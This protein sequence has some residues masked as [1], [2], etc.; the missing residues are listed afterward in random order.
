MFLWGKELGSSV[1]NNHLV[2]ELILLLGD[3]VHQIQRERG[4]A[5]L[6]IDSMGRIFSRRFLEQTT[7][8]DQSIQNFQSFYM[9]TEVR[10]ALPVNFE[11]RLKILSKKYE[12]LPS[13]RDNIHLMSTRYTKALNDYTFQ[14]SLP[15]IDAMIELAQRAPDHNSALVSA[16]SNFVQWKEKVGLER[17]LGARGFY[18]FS[19]RNQEFCDR[20]VTLIA[21]QKSYQETFKALASPSQLTIAQNAINDDDLSALASINRLLE[22]GAPPNEIEKYDGETWFELLTRMIDKL[23]L[24]EIELVKS[25][26]GTGKTVPSLHSQKPS[27]KKGADALLTHY[28]PFLKSL[29][30]FAAIDDHDLEEIL[31]FAQVREYSKD[32]LLFMRDEPATRLYI[33]LDGWVKVYNG[34]ETGEEAI[35]QMLGSGETLLESAV[36]LNVPAPVSAQVVEHALLLSV[37]APVI[38]QRI[39]SN[40]QLAVNMLNAVSIRSQRLVQQIELSRL[41]S[42]QERVG[43]FL[44]RLALNQK[45]NDGVIFLPYEK[46]IIAAYLDMRPETF[47]RTLQKFKKE[48]FQ[49]SADQ[50][51]IPKRQALCDYCDVELAGHC[52]IAHTP[53]CPRPELSEMMFD[54]ET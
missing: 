41:K 37:P 28:K 20:F 52:Q 32:K 12:N 1:K 46:S 31:S 5:S 26:A 18:T 39:Q 7:I 27:Q 10:D 34:L 35:L 24:A 3:L 11:S 4:S 21:E 43:W 45:T 51:Q 53:D 14:Y 40:P 16:F 29:P 2:Q 38:R 25:L 54:A 30:T 23:R 8:V 49:V 50:V 19:F 44:L 36:F 13:L 22:D 9:R 42:A 47:S 15:T 48:G 33:V 6:Y 17:A